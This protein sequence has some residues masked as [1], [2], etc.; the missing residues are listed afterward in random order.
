MKKERSI[1]RHQFNVEFI[2]VFLKNIQKKRM[3]ENKLHKIYLK[4]PKG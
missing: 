2:H 3:A 4:L 1:G